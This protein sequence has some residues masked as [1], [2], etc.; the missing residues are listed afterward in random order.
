MSREDGAAEL[1]AVV[2][3]MSRTRESVFDGLSAEEI[4]TLVRAVRAGE[5]DVFADQLT[6]AQRA[7]AMLGMVPDFR[8]S[9]EDEETP[10]AE[11]RDVVR[12]LGLVPI[13]PTKRV[14]RAVGEDAP[15]LVDLPLAVDAVS[16]NQG[17]AEGTNGVRQAA[18]R[19]LTEQ[20]PDPARFGE[21]T[22]ADARHGQRRR[23]RRGAPRDAD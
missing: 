13:A 6:R 2:A 19:R 23:V 20:R 15:A 21:P 14:R 1:R 16:E 11:T 17:I 9:E 8:V 10:D 12:H 7:A 5:W 3:I 18:D 22:S 4:L